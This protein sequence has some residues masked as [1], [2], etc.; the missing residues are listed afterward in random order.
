[1]NNVLDNI[2][3]P[4]GGNKR[5]NIRKGDHDIIYDYDIARLYTNPKRV[6][7]PII[8]CH[9]ED[10]P[11][12]EKIKR[13]NPTERKFPSINLPHGMVVISYEY[14]LQINIYDILDNS[15]KTIM[16]EMLDS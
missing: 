5:V 12:K 13:H 2:H 1:M 16:I 11:I 7:E 3:S 4:V 9:S 10:I 6:I 8:P 14:F 15:P